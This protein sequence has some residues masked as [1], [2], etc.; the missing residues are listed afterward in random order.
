MTV[1]ETPQQR[2]LRHRLS[3]YVDK[4]RGILPAETVDLLEE[5]LAFLHDAAYAPPDVPRSIPWDSVADLLWRVMRF[6]M[7]GDPRDLIDM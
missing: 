5:V 3:S 7:E 1:M 4:N 2:E 6:L